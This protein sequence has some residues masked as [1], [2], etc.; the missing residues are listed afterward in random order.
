MQHNRE[1]LAREVLIEMDVVE[2]APA[3][4]RGVAPVAV[5]IDQLV[6]DVDKGVLVRRCKEDVVARKACGERNAPREVDGRRIV[7]KGR[8]YRVVVLLPVKITRMKSDDVL[9]LWIPLQDGVL[10]AHI[11][12]Q[13]CREETPRD[14]R[15]SDEE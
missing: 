14:H 12:I 10:G 8:R 3:R 4:C 13:R 15:C 7:W 5:Q 9:V 2:R 1:P 11:G 6:I